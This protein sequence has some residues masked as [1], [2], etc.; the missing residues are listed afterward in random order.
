MTTRNA[1]LTV[2]IAFTVARQERR[3][4]CEIE[5]SHRQQTHQVSALRRAQRCLLIGP[6]VSEIRLESRQHHIVAS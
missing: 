2:S 4:H 1:P 5:C 6:R 3:D